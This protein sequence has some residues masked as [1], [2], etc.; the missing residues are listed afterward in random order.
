MLKQG[1]SVA[2]YSSF[3]SIGTGKKLLSL[4]QEAVPALPQICAISVDDELH[5]IPLAIPLSVSLLTS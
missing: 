4:Y 1:L 2:F 5:T 3:H